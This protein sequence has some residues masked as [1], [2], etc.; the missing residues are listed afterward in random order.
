MN[1][2]IRLNNLNNKLFLNNVMSIKYAHYMTE[3]LPKL[4]MHILVMRFKYS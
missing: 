2:S 3:R 4:S 1:D